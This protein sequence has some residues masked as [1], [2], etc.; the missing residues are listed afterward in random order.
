MRNAPKKAAQSVSPETIAAEITR[1]S[2]FPLKDLKAAWSAEFCRDVPKGMWRDLLLR[3]LDWRREWRRE[4]GAKSHLWSPFADGRRKPRKRRANL[5]AEAR[6]LNRG[7]GWLWAQSCP[8]RSP[9]IFPDK[10]R[11]SVAETRKTEDAWRH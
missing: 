9:L 11:E 2:R 5:K 3:T 1:F 7:T 10:H 8:N 4:T 6:P